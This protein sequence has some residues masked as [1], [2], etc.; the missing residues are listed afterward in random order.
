[1]EEKKRWLRFVVCGGGPIGVE[2]AAEL[3]DFIEEDV[4]RKYPKIA[5]LTETI[6]VEIGKKLLN[7]FDEKL[8]KYTMKL[9]RRENI[10]IKTESSIRKITGDTIFLNDGTQTNY[11]LLVWATG[12]TSSKLVEQSSFPKTKRNKI[13]IDDFFKV[14][15]YD[16]IYALGD[17]AELES[18]ALPVTAQVAQQQGKYLGKA[19]NKLASNKNVKPF[20]F[21]DF[22]MLAYIGDQKALADMPQ[23]KSTGFKTFIFW[24]S[25]YI[26]KLVSLKNKILV[27]FDWFKTFVFGRDVSNF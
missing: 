20:K 4:K 5:D 2:F 26:T 17:C 1:M 23:I 15:N 25:V 24:R 8:S 13:L 6:L 7:T 22:G 9:F 18:G 19:F 27:L 10:I 11:G 21:H 3:H 14:K 16:N 12:N